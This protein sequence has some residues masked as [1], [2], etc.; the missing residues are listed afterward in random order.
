MK[1]IQGP[2]PQTNKA[3]CHSAK[4][5][6]ELL[7]PNSATVAMDYSADRH[8]GFVTCELDLSFVNLSLEAG[9]SLHLESVVIIEHFLPS[10]GQHFSEV[11]A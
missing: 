2:V 5:R 8:R 3:P 1:V 4:Q 7:S 10:D 11:T 9:H 6:A